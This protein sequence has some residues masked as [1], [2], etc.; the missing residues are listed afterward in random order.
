MISSAPILLS[1]MLPGTHRQT[2]AAGAAAMARGTIVS[3]A[4]TVAFS[5]V[6]ASSLPQMRVVP[7]LLLATAVLCT[8]IAATPL[9]DQASGRSVRR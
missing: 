1:I 6:L 5:A 2:G 9:L 4:A 3:M 7:S 8:L